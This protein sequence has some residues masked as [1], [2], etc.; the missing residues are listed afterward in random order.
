MMN[1]LI[2]VR[3]STNVDVCDNAG[4]QKLTR[5]LVKFHITTE[6][7]LNYRKYIILSIIGLILEHCS[8]A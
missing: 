6:H 3:N 2:K 1:A 7:Y 8:K 4:V 5:I